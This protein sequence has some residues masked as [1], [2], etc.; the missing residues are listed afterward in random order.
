MTNEYNSAAQLLCV[1]LGAPADV[2]MCTPALRA[3]RAQCSGRRVT[4]L[5]SHAG[6]ALAPCLPDIDA[7]LAYAA[8]WMNDGDGPSHLA[9]IAALAAHG[10][11]GAVIFTSERESALPAALLCQLAGI[12]L[13]AGWCR[14][15][16]GGLLTHSILDPEPG[17]MRRHPVQRQLDLVRRLG[18]QIA[19][20]R[21]AFV[22]LE[23][24]VLAVR[25]RL[26]AAGIDPGERWLA[27]HPGAGAQARRYPLQHW[28]ALIGMLHARVKCPLVLT[29]SA[30]D[31]ALMDAID[32]PP[33]ARIHSVA[34]Q[35]EIGE[36]GALLAQAALVVSN[37]QATAQLAAAVATP[38]IDLGELC[39]DVDRHD[40]LERLTPTRVADTVCTLLKRTGADRIRD[41]VPA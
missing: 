26:Q 28:S 5:A 31:L 14:E 9:W 30:R 7:V 34:G 18:A 22:P 3:L 1:Q 24:D 40:C 23:Q 29:G 2:V 32:L 16:P 33:G 36:L 21:L 8:P 15:H 11:D 13:R 4:L 27:L 17:A 25:T 39:G 38:A 41:V 20:E 6:A 12:P 19:D 37:S 35:G 10:F